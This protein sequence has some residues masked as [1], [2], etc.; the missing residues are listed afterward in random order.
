MI[1]YFNGWQDKFKLEVPMIQLTT[2]DENKDAKETTVN[3]DGDG[4]QSENI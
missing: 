4:N 2:L 3:S 1:M